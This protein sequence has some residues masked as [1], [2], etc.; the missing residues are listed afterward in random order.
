M[1]EWK[2]HGKAQE[3]I[4]ELKLAQGLDGQPPRSSRF[5]TKRDAIVRTYEEPVWPRLG[6]ILFFSMLL[7]TA[8]MLM[9]E[10]STYL[11]HSSHLGVRHLLSNLAVTGTGM[12]GLYTALLLPVCIA[13]CLSNARRFRDRQRES[14]TQDDTEEDRARSDRAIRR[15]NRSFLRY[16]AVSLTGLALWVLLSLAVTH[17]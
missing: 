2:L 13:G 9:A 10:I 17:G 1:E 14:G 12:W 11:R 16:M 15:L 8:V 3:C 6:K 5:Q 4:E 7:L